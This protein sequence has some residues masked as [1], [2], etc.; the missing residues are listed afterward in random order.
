MV[1]VRGPQ[2]QRDHVGANH[3]RLII[4]NA[5]SQMEPRDSYAYS[6]YSGDLLLE[7]IREN[8]R[9]Y[10]YLVYIIIYSIPSEPPNFLLFIKKICEIILINLY[11]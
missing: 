3:S 4:Q 10:I 9:I 11:I 7:N 8:K 2:V 6:I 5:R 1:G